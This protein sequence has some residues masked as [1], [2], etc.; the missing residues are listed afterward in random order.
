V[1]DI[2][3]SVRSRYIM[4]VV[5]VTS[6][7]YHGQCFESVRER[8]AKADYASTKAEEGV[9]FSWNDFESAEPDNHG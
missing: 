2:S 4:R 6:R 3:N 9:N 5:H 8:S 7:T 1:N